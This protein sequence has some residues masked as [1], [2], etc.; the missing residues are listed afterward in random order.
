MTY[1]EI[2]KTNPGFDVPEDIYNEYFPE[3][4]KTFNGH[5]ENHAGRF[6]CEDWRAFEIA[7]RGGKIGNKQKADSSRAG[8]SDRKG[9]ARRGKAAGEGSG[10]T[11]S[12]STGGTPDNG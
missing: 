6:N 1:K 5:V 9:F 12:D 11:R 8:K 2:K 3:F 4:K 7:Y 10:S